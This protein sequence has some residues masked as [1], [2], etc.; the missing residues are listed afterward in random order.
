MAQVNQRLWKIPGQRTKRKA[1][2]FTAQING[3]Q[4]RR[5]KA[6]W[7]QDDAEAELAKALLK[8]EPEKAKRP[9]LTLDQAVDRYLAAKSRKRS[10]SEDKRILGHLKDYFGKH[11]P[12]SEITASSISEYKGRR[13]SSARKIGEGE[14]AIERP[15]AGATVNRA[16]ALLRHLLR[17]A[18]EEW[19][20]LDA[21]PRIRMEREAEGRLRWLTPEEATRLLDACRKSRN[22]H[23]IDLVEFA[24]FTGMRRGEVLGLTWERVDRAR[25][26]VL[27]DVT[28]S[29]KRRE[30]PLNSRADAVLA[31][32]GSKS[33]GLVFGTWRWD[34]FR[35]AWENAVERSKLADFHFHDLRHTFASW[36]VQRGASLQEVK[37]PLGHRSLA[38]TLRYG[39]LAPEHLRTA[40]ARLDAALPVP[41]KLSAQGSA[42]EGVT[43][44]ALLS[45]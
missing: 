40:V 12:L 10:L 15:L 41:T 3:K 31:R 13:L 5:Y 27:L 38:M 22:G 45:K 39:H 20:L 2:G 36:A 14:T 42:Q 43:E 9:G 11:T 32:R 33:S 28:K 8:I 23:L 35:T 37:D 6:E 44:G 17:L 7:T 18:H 26:V 24:L 25:G 19:E 21:V 34:N 1:W 4:V 29:G 16:L 30:V